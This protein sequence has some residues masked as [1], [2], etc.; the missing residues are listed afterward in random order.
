[1]GLLFPLV[2]LIAFI[3]FMEL[4]GRARE[5]FLASMDPQDR[6]E[7]LKNE[8]EKNRKREESKEDEAAE[9][10]I[11]AISVARAEGRT[12]ARA[13]VRQRDYFRIQR[14]AARQG[15]T[16]TYVKHGSHG[17]VQFTFSGFPR[18]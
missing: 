4:K 12:Y 10:A 18:G 13:W 5:K 17:D 3:A 11:L 1:M 6:E 15:Y 7:F 8:E 16:A 14:W 9:S 2:A